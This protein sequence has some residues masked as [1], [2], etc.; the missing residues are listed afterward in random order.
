MNKLGLHFPS[1]DIDTQ[2][3]P[4]TL[5]QALVNTNLEAA[6]RLIVLVPADT[7]YAT[8]T[9][10]V[11]ELANTL[12]CHVL[13]LSLCPDPVQ[14][15]SLR[16]QLVTMSAMVQDGKVCAEARVESGPSW[17]NAVKSNVRDGDM[18]VCFA[19]QRAGLL[20][21]P[22]SQILQANLETPVYI[23]SGL[24]PQKF[25]RPTWLSQTLGWIGSIGIIAGAFLLQIQI[26]S[27]SENWAQT[28]LLIL[29]M[30]GEIGL[31]WGWN[32]L[33]S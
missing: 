2:S 33:L 26:L 18:I 32:S 10:R 17:V 28:T 14:E 8:V 16:R 7:N 12:A 9:Q 19:E 13:L 27:L 5:P 23:L 29:S 15:S 22:L 11:W 31:I 6:R 25:S 24:S 4:A 3:D 30:L 21:R 1:Y 20:H